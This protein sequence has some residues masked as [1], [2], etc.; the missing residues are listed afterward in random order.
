MVDQ[1]YNS[2]LPKKYNP[3][4]WWGD[5]YQ[6]NAGF[7]EM[8]ARINALNPTLVIDAGCGRNNHKAHI[9][10]LIGFDAS[11]FTGVDIHC[12]ILE[13]PFEPNCADAVLVLGSIQF[14]SREYIIENMERVISWLKPEGLIEMRSL[15]N[16]NTTKNWLET[17]TRQRVKVLW[18]EDLRKYFVDKFNLRY[19]KTPWIYTATAPLDDKWEVR[20]AEM[21]ATSKRKEEKFLYKQNLK[22]ECWT[23]I[24]N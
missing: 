6:E 14:I 24:K 17:Y 20:K 11:P 15:L 3:D 10:N 21:K 2:G 8:Y 23:W 13:A 18:D 7:E 12:P 1:Y 5:S 19:I 4:E 16:D 22:R 9:K